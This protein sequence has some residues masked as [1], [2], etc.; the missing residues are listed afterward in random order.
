MSA[1]QLSLERRTIW[2]KRFNNLGAAAVRSARYV[3]RISKGAD[4][5]RLPVEQPTTFAPNRNVRKVCIVIL[6]MGTSPVMAYSW[7][8]NR[9][10]YHSVVCLALVFIPRIMPDTI[11]PTP[12][13]IMREIVVREL[14]ASALD[15]ISS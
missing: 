14:S 4:P 11:S 3:D 15:G 1:F 10:Y 12:I 8:D 9:G 6:L 13:L 2:T 7:V 5:S